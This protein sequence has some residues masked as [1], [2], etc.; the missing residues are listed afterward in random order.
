MRREIDIAVR[1]HRRVV[2]HRAV[3]E[4]A[5]DVERR[6]PSAVRLPRDIPEVRAGETASIHRG[7]YRRSARLR[8]PVGDE[9]QALAV[10][11]QRRFGVVPL[12]GERG[13]L[14]R[15]PAARG[16]T[17][18]QDGV[19]G[20]GEIRAHEVQRPAVRRQRGR[21]FLQAGGDHAGAEQLAGGGCLRGERGRDAGGEDEVA[22][23]HGH[24]LV[25]FRRIAPAMPAATEVTAGGASPATAPATAARYGCC[26]CPTR[27]CAPGPR[28]PAPAS[29][30]SP[31][32]P[33][34]C[35]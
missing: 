18:D 14:R 30:G 20:L 16:A 21:G 25:G 27:A 19:V 7:R 4:R 33:C 24:L 17:R 12:A 10:G 3:V 5:V 31:P 11:R 2:D 1:R 15:R 28:A 32:S 34:S 9:V 8:R 26:R 6:T 22:W 23:G 35:W 29:A 13:H